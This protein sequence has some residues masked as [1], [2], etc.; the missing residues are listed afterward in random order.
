VLWSARLYERNTSAIGGAGP[1]VSTEP[2]HRHRRGSL[3][4]RR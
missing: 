3:M 4:S 2:A 1:C